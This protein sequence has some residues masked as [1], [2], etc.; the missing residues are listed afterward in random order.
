MKYLKFRA[1]ISQQVNIVLAYFKA[2][3]RREN[4]NIFRL[5]VNLARNDKKWD[6]LSDF[7]TGFWLENEI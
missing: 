5:K 6:I 7:Q 3:F 1:K 2:S 4:S